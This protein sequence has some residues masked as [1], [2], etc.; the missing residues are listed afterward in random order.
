MELEHTAV[1]SAHIG[2]GVGIQVTERAH[3]HDSVYRVTG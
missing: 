3:D 1:D 2:G